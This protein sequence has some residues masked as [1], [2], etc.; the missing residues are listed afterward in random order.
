M[1][2]CVPIFVVERL[3]SILYWY[4]DVRL[5]SLPNR[6]IICVIFSARGTSAHTPLYEQADDTLV[7]NRLKVLDWI[8]F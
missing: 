2:N 8:V 1:R 7:N 6:R 4:K 3:V 5:T